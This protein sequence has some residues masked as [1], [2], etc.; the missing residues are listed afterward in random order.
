MALLLT[1]FWILIV[2]ARPFRWWKAAVIAGAALLAVGAFVLP[3]AARFFN[4][5]LPA[6]LFL[7]SLAVGAVGSAAIEV[8]YRFTHHRLRNL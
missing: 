2:L 6:S 7:E 8:L 1:F 5:D 4:F 3:T